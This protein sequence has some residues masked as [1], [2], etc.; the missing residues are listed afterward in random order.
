[1]PPIFWEMG[2]LSAKHKHPAWVP[3][4]CVC[5]LAMLAGWHHCCLNIHYRGAGSTR[6]PANV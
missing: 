6:Q 1:M 4:V 2:D 5:D 3:G